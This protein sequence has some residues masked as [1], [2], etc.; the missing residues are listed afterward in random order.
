MEPIMDNPKFEDRPIAD[1]DLD[2]V[3]GGWINIPVINASKQRDNSQE[4]A[5]TKPWATAF[6]GQHDP[7]Y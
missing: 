7:L 2:A 6:S 3:S 4:L 5:L 1:A